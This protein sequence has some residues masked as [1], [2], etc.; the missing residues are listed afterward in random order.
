[1]QAANENRTIPEMA[2]ELRAGH[3]PRRNFVKALTALGVSATGAGIVAA[4]AT[5]GVFATKTQQVTQGDE[6]VARNL[7]LHDQH[8]AS[9]TQGDVNALHH[10]YAENAIV[11][12]SMYDQPFVGRA[13]IIS[14]KNVGM[15]AI[16]DL[17]INVLNRVAQNQQVMV[18][19]V[20]SGTHTGDFPNLPASG[21]SFSIRG[22]TV[23]VRENGQI[24]RESIY[25]NMDDVR[26]QLTSL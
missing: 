9:Q 7:R 17:Q 4:A 14:R 11:E 5:S 6:E 19:W 13:A 1:M 12:D 15:A 23:V 10:D 3:L 24:V 25:Y 18:E 8:L 21:R 22:V 20:A 2:E 26:N 16:P